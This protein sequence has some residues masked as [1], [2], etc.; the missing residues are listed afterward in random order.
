MNVFW[1]ATVAF[2]VNIPLGK[3]RSGY[4]KFSPLWLL[5]IHASMPLIIALRISHNIPHVYIPLFIAL[6]VFGQ[7]LGKNF[8]K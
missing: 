4:K 3:W 6:A 1:V 2:A 5:L 7:L 8:K